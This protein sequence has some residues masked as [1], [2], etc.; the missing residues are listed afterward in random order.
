MLFA[1]LIIYPFKYKEI[2]SAPRAIVIERKL[3]MTSGDKWFRIPEQLLVT[4][5]FIKSFDKW[6]FECHLLISLNIIF[7][8]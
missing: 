3:T 7:Q 1:M 6:H 5:L 2:Y 4:F 8:F